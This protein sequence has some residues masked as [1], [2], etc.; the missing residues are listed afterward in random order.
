MQV[1]VE[2]QGEGVQ[3]VHV[4][5]GDSATSVSQVPSRLTTWAAASRLTPQMIA[6]RLSDSTPRIISFIGR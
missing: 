1:D 6:L 5:T 4:F 2:P 3:K